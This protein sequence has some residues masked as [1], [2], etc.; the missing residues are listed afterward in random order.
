[1]FSQK[2]IKELLEGKILAN[3]YNYFVERSR[4][5]QKTKVLSKVKS[6]T[7]KI[8]KFSQEEI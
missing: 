3:K 7:K 2:D 4:F 6:L 1:M 5:S 8:Y